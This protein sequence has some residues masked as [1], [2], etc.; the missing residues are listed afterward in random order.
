[1]RRKQEGRYTVTGP[2]EEDHA[3]PTIGAGISCAQSF[4]SKHRRA[5]GE[6]TYYV[7]DLVGGVL[8]AT[9]TKGADGSITT[10]PSY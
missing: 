10:W 6:I 9:I 8:Y 1:M 4:A 7:R 5:E 2:H 3:V